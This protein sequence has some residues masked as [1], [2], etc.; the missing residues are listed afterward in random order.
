MTEDR[1]RAR[2]CLRHTERAYIGV[3]A[4]LSGWKIRRLELGKSE[5]FLDVPKASGT[6]TDGFCLA[7]TIKFFAILLWVHDTGWKFVVYG[8]RLLGQA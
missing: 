6:I 4:F 7:V 1:A 2:R 5:L 3:A 8:G